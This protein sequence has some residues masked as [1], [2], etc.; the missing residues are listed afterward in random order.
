MVSQTLTA[1]LQL[2]IKNTE[3]RN[4]ESP[5]IRGRIQRGV[6]PSDRSEFNMFDLTMNPSKELSGGHKLP[7]G[8][9]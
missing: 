5:Q 9:F 8:L 6:T 3:V 4:Q 1:R 7:K 2:P